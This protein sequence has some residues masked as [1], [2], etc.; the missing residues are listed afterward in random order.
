[1]SE[2]NPAPEP[3]QHAIT[4]QVNLAVNMLID[5]S[6]TGHYTPH[7]ETCGQHMPPGV[8]DITMLWVQAHLMQHRA[9]MLQQA[10]NFNY[11][12]VR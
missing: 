7:C 1:M 10:F 3:R 2:P 9:V 4:N 5:D 11:F 6:G 12:G 8:L